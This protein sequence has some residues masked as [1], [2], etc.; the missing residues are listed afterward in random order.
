ML[1]NPWPQVESWH[2][3]LKYDVVESL[4]IPMRLTQ[5]ATNRIVANGRLPNLARKCAASCATT[6]VANR[7]GMAV[8][9]CG[10][11]ILMMTVL[12]LC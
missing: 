11:T 7:K 9:L 8:L 12:Y 4:S 3:M 2:G 1:I 6:R 5:A 10:Y